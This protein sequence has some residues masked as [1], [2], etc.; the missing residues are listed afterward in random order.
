MTGQLIQGVYHYWPNM[1]ISAG[2]DVIFL[3]SVIFKLRDVSLANDRVGMNQRIAAGGTYPFERS[4]FELLTSAPTTDATVAVSY[5]SADGHAYQLTA[6]TAVAPVESAPATAVL[7]I[8]NFVVTRWRDRIWWNYWPRFAVTETSGAS[9]ATITRIVF[10]MP[11]LGV[12][13]SAPP[14]FGAWPIAAGGSIRLFD[15]WSYDEPAFYLSDGSLFDRVT[16]TLSYVDAAG[17][18]GDV[19]ATAQVTQN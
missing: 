5:T 17:R 16:V 3:K 19:T 12:N 13:G 4:H 18:P 1:T 7:Q 2:G 14:S 6:A 8:S 11:D 10:T 15:E 9:A